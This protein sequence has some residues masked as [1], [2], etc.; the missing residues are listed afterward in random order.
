M[1]SVVEIETPEKMDT[2]LS[3]QTDGPGLSVSAG[4]DVSSDGGA[5]TLRYLRPDE[6]TTIWDALV[7][8]S[9]QGSPFVRSWWLNAIGGTVKVLGYFK[10]GS[11]IAG[12]PLY[13]EKRFGITVYT[14]PK[15]TQTLGPVLASSPGKQV[16]ALWQ[17]M[18]VLSAFAK[19]LAK[20]RVFFQ[21]FHPSLHNWSPFYWNGFSQTSRA[22]QVLDLTAPD[23]L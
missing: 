18:E 19:E 13:S 6:L 5:G 17:E 21:A 16:A 1:N 2:K 20:F 23:K 14:M 7:D 3:E 9:P 11:L 8:I 12:I 10:G 22:T 4:G 15:L